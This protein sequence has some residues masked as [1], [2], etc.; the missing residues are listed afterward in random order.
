MVVVSSAAFASMG[1]VHFVELIAMFVNGAAGLLDSGLTL[2][3]E[4]A[5]FYLGSLA[6]PLLLVGVLARRSAMTTAVASGLVALVLVAMGRHGGLH[7]SLFELSPD[8]VGG[9][10]GMGRAL[11]PGAI[12]IAFLAGVGIDELKDGNG[13]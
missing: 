6:F 9:L 1:S 11:G 12:G 5:S 7:A 10:R 2:D 13:L 8:L 4:G 3:H